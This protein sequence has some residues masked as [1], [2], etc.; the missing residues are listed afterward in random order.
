MNKLITDAVRGRACGRAWRLR[1]G[2]TGLLLLVAVLGPTSRAVAA[3]GLRELT[4]YSSRYYTIHTNLL[5]TEAVS[6]GAH[7]DLVF[8]SYAKRLRTL[9]GKKQDRQN[10]Y[11]LR[12][13]ADYIKT[14]QDIGLNGTGTGGVFFWAGQ[15][16][17]LATWVEGRP[18]G[19]TLAVL[20]HEGFHQFAR[21]RLGDQL[22]IWVNEG[23]A[24]YF[25][26][27]I[28]VAGKLR[29]GIV[30]ADRLAI[31]QRA[32]ER[33]TAFPFGQLLNRTHTQWNRAVSSGDAK[34]GLQY[35]QS[36]SIVHFLAHGD[37]G[38][39]E[40][41]FN[42]YLIGLSKGEGHT[43]AF[44]KAFGSED[45]AP[46]AKRWRAFIETAEPDNFSEAVN[47]VQF[48]AAGM[49][50]TGGDAGWPDS[51][52]TL[53]QRMTERGF[54]LTYNGDGGRQTLKASDPKW[55]GYL[56]DAGQEQPFELRVAESSPSSPERQG[57]ADL[58]PTLVAAGLN[59]P[60][61]LTWTR[62]ADGAL[63]AEVT[64]GEV[65]RRRR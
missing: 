13:H 29:S 11:L 38:R 30:D 22:P 45:T 4:R 17:G 41:A 63:K 36:W 55:Y 62:D 12:T 21:A 25:E 59:P 20:Q 26:H 37:N 19:R 60:V 6:Y 1:W 56:D 42:R 49:R 58:P 14:L 54:R 53:R 65:S 35:A 15:R 64:Y 16:S 57:A 24:E 48:L 10:L 33:D 7:M 9:R 28:V 50:A 5:R 44:S 27:S 2:L 31:V 8:A 61:H 51:L 40:G 3:D 32:I 34:A 52:E 46:F 43:Q 23:L 39:Y 18:R 47:R